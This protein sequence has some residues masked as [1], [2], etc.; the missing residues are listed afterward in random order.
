MIHGEFLTLLP[1][2]ESGGVHPKPDEGVS[3]GG[4]F[5]KMHERLPRNIKPIAYSIIH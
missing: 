2:M 4:K 1:L 5:G 3:D